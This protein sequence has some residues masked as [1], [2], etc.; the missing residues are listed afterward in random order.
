MIEIEKRA[1][2]NKQKFNSLQNFFKKNGKFIKTFKRYTLLQISREDF[3]PN[4]DAKT[5]IRVRTDGTEA[6]LTVKSGNWHSGESRQEF[7]IHF[8][9]AEIKDAVGMMLALSKPYFVTVY[10]ER[11]VCE[12]K[13]YEV[14]LDKYYFND[15]YILEIELKEDVSKEKIEK[16][17]KLIYKMLEEFEVEPLEADGMVEFITKLNF[18]EECQINFE[19]IS[20]DEWYEKWEDFIFCRP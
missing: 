8:D 17:E 5:D 4:K 13:K 12:Y 18:V 11:W 3:Y 20:L 1:L 7:E 6:K 19:K 16:E 14:S 2:L 9:L 10:F 15:D